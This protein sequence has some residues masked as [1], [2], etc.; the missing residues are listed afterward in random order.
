MDVNLTAVYE[1]AF[2]LLPLPALLV[3]PTGEFL[4][5]TYA[6]LETVQ[7]TTPCLKACPIEQ[8]WEPLDS[9]SP[10]PKLA[11]TWSGEVRWIG[12]N[13]Q[14]TAVRLVVRA[15]GEDLSHGY[16]IFAD[17][18]TVFQSSVTTGNTRQH[19]GG[20]AKAIDLGSPQGSPEEKVVLTA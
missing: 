14:S 6:F 11:D 8:Q 4:N 10:V 3:S 20:T 16:L 18:S 19:L 9:K 12:E 7:S 1:E 5:V 17:T 13:G 15:L 2:L